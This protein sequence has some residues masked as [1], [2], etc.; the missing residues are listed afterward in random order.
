MMDLS[1]GLGGDAGHLAAASQVGVQ[2]DLGQLPV[3]PSVAAAAE[4]AGQ[5]PE[6]F[7]A[8]AGEDYELLVTLPR[9]FDGAADFLRDTGLPLTRVGTVTDGRGVRATLG[10]V[11]QSVRGFEHQL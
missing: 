11:V 7:A 10:G 9:G 8:G 6:V 4:R 5:A 1:D 3:H 2:I